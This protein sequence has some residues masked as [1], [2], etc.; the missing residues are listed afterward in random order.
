MDLYIDFKLL[1]RCDIKITSCLSSMDQLAMEEADSYNDCSLDAFDYNDEGSEGEG[2]DVG[3]ENHEADSH[4]PS[5]PRC[6]MVSNQSHHRPIKMM[7]NY[8][9]IFH[10]N[11][12]KHVM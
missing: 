8:L 7:V 5:T 6:I 11:L 3:Q 12:C 10:S 4:L 1:C 9:L 2:E